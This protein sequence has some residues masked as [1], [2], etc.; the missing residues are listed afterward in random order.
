MAKECLGF[1]RALQLWERLI[2]AKDACGTVSISRKVGTSRAV[3][4]V[5][6]GVFVTHEFATAELAHPRPGL[7][8]RILESLADNKPVIT[9]YRYLAR[10]NAAATLNQV[11][12]YCGTRSELLTPDDETLVRGLMA[13]SYAELFLGYRIQRMLTEVQGEADLAAL[14][15]YPA[16]EIASRYEDYFREQG[17][18]SSG[19]VLCVAQG[20]NFRKD[21]SSFALPIYVGQPVPRFELSRGEKELLKGALDGL[22][23]AHLAVA[24]C[25]S[26]SALKRRWRRIFE[27]IASIDPSVCPDVEGPLRGPQRRHHV[28]NYIRAHP[29][30]IRPFL[31]SGAERTRSN[32]RAVT[33]RPASH[34]QQG[35]LEVTLTRG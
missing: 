11:V 20:A 32:T 21:L 7:N 26:E 17:G 23:D 3:V 10:A 28:L 25:R 14:A 5:A 1:N 22:E 16:I 19:S 2:A 33:G 12:M 30:E 9:D 31:S 8:A 18:A 34:G 6:V 24:L 13:R 29:E 27:K 15:G 4:A 35:A